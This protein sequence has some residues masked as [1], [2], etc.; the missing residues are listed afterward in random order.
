MRIDQELLEQ[1][2]VGNKQE[3]GQEAI[4][5][6]HNYTML[7]RFRQGKDFKEIDKYVTAKSESTA[8]YDS[9][10]ENKWWQN[11]NKPISAAQKR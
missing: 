4:P 7:Q 1:L 6:L 9:N 8:K 11:Q 3:L 2:G 10:K 5:D